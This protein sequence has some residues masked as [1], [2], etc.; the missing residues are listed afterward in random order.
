MGL[1]QA[2][3]VPLK[4]DERIERLR[5]D[6][7]DALNEQQALLALRIS[8]GDTG[9][10]IDL[11][12]SPGSS[13]QVDEDEL[14]E[15]IWDDRDQVYRCV[16]CGFEVCDGWCAGA[17]CNRAHAYD[18]G[19]E[20]DDDFD[21][22]DCFTMPPS[23]RLPHPRG[24]TP[25]L[26]VAVD[27]APVSFSGTFEAYRA[28]L[29]RGATPAMVELFRLQWSADNG[30]VAYATPDLFHDWAGPAMERG[31]VWKIALGRK[32]TLDENDVDGSRW[33]RD[34]LDEF[35]SSSAWETV[36]ERHGEWVTRPKVKDDN[37]APEA[38]NERDSPEPIAYW[39]EYEETSSE[40]EDVMDGAAAS[41]AAHVAAE[42]GTATESSEDEPIDGDY[43]DS[44]QSQSQSEDNAGAR[45]SHDA[46][47]IDDESPDSDQP[48]SDWDSQEDLSG[49]ETA[50][51]DAPDIMARIK[52]IP[53]V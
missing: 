46:M 25:L 23:V 13:S 1:Y 20:D 53:L 4:L 31:D 47:E 2:Q 51:A 10:V 3:R 32:I 50:L 44:D 34:F 35:L 14:P 41:S 43:M 11:T 45:I 30:I 48:G 29:Q 18:S 33:I 21:N 26:G 17:E 27:A 49:D 12:A 40:D 42:G 15:P 8:R 6:L 38:E 16:D 52:W 5:R 28:L 7:A 9:A 19:S 37:A 22:T 36:R 39:D 24:T